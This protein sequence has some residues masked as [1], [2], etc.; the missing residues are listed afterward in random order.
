[1]ATI[2]G[3]PDIFILPDAQTNKLTFYYTPTTDGGSNITS[4]FLSSITHNC[5]VSIPL[6]NPGYFTLS[7]LSNATEYIFQIAASNSVGLGPY[8]QYLPVQPGDVPPDPNLSSISGLSLFLSTNSFYKLNIIP[9]STINTP[10][11]KYFVVNSIRNA[12]DSNS[13]TCSSLIQNIFTTDNTSLP[14]SLNPNF[15]WKVNIQSVT[16]TGYSFSN[17]FYDVPFNN[18]SAVL[19]GWSSIT[20]LDTSLSFHTFTSAFSQV[21]TSV[22][23]SK[24]NWSYQSAYGHNRGFTIMFR[25][26]QNTSTFQSYFINSNASFVYSSIVFSTSSSLATLFT[27]PRNAFRAKDYFFYPINQSNIGWY[28]FNWNTSK[29]SYGILNES[30]IT[31][32]CSDYVTSNTI[33]ICRSTSTDFMH[34]LYEIQ[35]KPENPENSQPTFLHSF[36]NYF[37]D[38]NNIS[39]NYAIITGHSTSNYWDKLF[40]FNPSTPTQTYDLTPLNIDSMRSIF[41]LSDKKLYFYNSR[42]STIASQSYF[43]F[44]FYYFDF[45]YSSSPFQFQYSFSTLNSPILT[46]YGSRYSPTY[47]GATSLFQGAFFIWNN[48]GLFFSPYNSSR[49]L[50]T[51]SFTD[52]TGTLNNSSRFT[53]FPYMS[54]TT[55]M[56]SSVDDS[57]SINHYSVVDVL[58]N[59]TTRRSILFSNTNSLGYIINN[60]ANPNNN[61]MYTFQY[62]NSTMYFF[63][64]NIGAN[65]TI[66]TA[67]RTSNA[68][69]NFF[70]FTNTVTSYYVGSNIQPYALP[71][72]EF[73]LTGWRSLIPSTEASFGFDRVT[74]KI[75][76][77]SNNSLVS[78]INFTYTPLGSFFDGVADAAICIPI[79]SN[80]NT[81]F[82][83][84]STNGLITLGVF[85][86]NLP[87]NFSSITILNYTVVS[88]KVNYGMIFRFNSTISGVNSSIRVAYNYNYSTNT[89]QTFSSILTGYINVPVYNANNTDRYFRT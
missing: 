29:D 42:S 35:Y 67:A 60:T 24:S 12:E 36:R 79:D 83:R 74:N 75:H 82:A 38:Y 88:N 76:V 15:D 27:T 25:N 89:F 30:T 20:E 54:N 8:S 6:S 77:M 84:I 43:V 47:Q 59:A 85:N 72:P 17:T 57:G 73:S 44:N 64:T 62:F 80:A 51:P 18:E 56:F 53:V 87:W 22:F 39:Q 65:S 14:I 4:Y 34:N 2:P 69:H 26:I 58:S 81:K 45:D 23:P 11:I 16:D 66:N 48:M 40:F 10:P 21:N 3:P 41:K 37:S 19:I 46:S 70:G 13:P 9:N 28:S 32:T 55:F 52:Y 49:I 31:D 1:M 5:N 50:S 63:S 86:S 78:S 71:K 33:L 61:Y 7:S 68:I